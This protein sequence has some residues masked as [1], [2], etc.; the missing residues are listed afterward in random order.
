MLNI[1]WFERPREFFDSLDNEN[2]HKIREAIT[3]LS[4][5]NFEQIYL[6]EVRGPIKELRVSSYRVLFCIEYSTV[7][8]LTAFQKKT[9]KTPR[10][11]VK[12]AQKLYALLLKEINKKII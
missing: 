4:D 7:Y 1:S 12:M 11:E 10:N 9:V 5:E 3:A 2:R 6:K 8:I